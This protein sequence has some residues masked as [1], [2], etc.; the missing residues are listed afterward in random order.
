MKHSNYLSQDMNNPEQEVVFTLQDLSDLVDTQGI[1][2]V[3][4]TVQVCFPTLFH[5]LSKYFLQHEKIKKV[6][7]LQC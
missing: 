2:Q 5:E 6:G 4:S 7:K 1:H 3:M